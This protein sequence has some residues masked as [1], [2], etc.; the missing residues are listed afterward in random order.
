MTTQSV[1]DQL[2]TALAEERRALL[3]QDVPGLLASSQ[4]KRAAL[5]AL[6]SEP[7]HGQHERLEELARENRF[8]GTLLSRRR[9]EVEMLLG[10][11]GQQQQPHAY[12]ARGQT[13]KTPLQR[14]LAVA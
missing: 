2:A 9:R 8:N 11:F 7:A 10:Y 12:D 1:L 13:Q 14:V 5:Q 4:S 3:A 6:E